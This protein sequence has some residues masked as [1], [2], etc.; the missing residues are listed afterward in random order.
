MLGSGRKKKVMLLE[1]RLTVHGVGKK[2][3]GPLSIGDRL[4]PSVYKIRIQGVKKVQ[5]K[6]VHANQIKLYK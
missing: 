5:D 1:S 4:S 6:W 2:W 3:K